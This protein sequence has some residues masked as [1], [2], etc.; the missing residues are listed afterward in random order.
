[1]NVLVLGA[2]G[3]LGRTLMRQHWPAGVSVQGATRADV[4]FA[5]PEHL[6]A[7]LDRFTCDLVVN[8]AAYTAVDLAESEPDIAGRVNSQS[9]GVIARWCAGRGIPLVHISTD[10]VFDGTKGELYV[11]TDPISPGNVYGRTKADGEV[12][13]RDSL[14]AHVILRTA[15]V[16]SADGGN[17]LTTMLNLAT[18]R[19]AL[20]IVDDQYGCPTATCDLARAIAVIVEQ[21]GDAGAIDWGTYHYAGGG[22]TTWFDF[23]QHLLEASV[24]FGGRL[25]DLTPIPTSAYPTP[26]ARPL[27]TRLECTKIARAFDVPFVDWRERSAHVVEEAMALMAKASP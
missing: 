16:Y 25:P 15:W 10:Y 1:M 24:E 13:V 17:F 9:P 14:D 8:A 20:R 26:A 7:Q 21:I 6:P 18:T 23:A 4:D 11:E 2:S 19:D 27:D 12:A 5:A 3:Q 22:S